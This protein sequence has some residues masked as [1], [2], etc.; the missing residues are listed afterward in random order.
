M[1]YT[2]ESEK[3]LNQM[4]KDIREKNKPEYQSLKYYV[5][6][7]LDKSIENYYKQLLESK[8]MLSNF[9]ELSVSKKLLKT[10]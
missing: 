8:N 5:D 4:L 7:R 3:I 6:M 10:F 1:T 2:T 9:N